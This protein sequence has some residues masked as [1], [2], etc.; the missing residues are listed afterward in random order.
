VVGILLGPLIR[1]NVLLSDMLKDESS[2]ADLVGP[3]LSA[4]KSLLEIPSHRASDSQEMFS[5]LVHGV[6]SACLV[7][8][9][10]MRYVFTPI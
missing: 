2:E 10:E 9:D 8:I 3:T 5:R 4:L 1:Y 6:L 7:N